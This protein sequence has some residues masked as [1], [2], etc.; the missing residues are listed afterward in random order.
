MLGLSDFQFFDFNNGFAIFQGL[1]FETA[2]GGEHWR[3]VELGG[4]L[5]DIMFF[6]NDRQG[7]IAG[8]DGML[9][10]TTDSGLNWEKLQY[11]KNR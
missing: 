10:H 4:E 3:Q 8:K 1:L 11:D 9:L 6:L 7:W 5:G 2:D